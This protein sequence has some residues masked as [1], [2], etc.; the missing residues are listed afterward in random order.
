MRTISDEDFS[1]F[2]DLFKDVHGFRPRGLTPTDPEEFDRQYVDLLVQLQRQLDEQE[3]EARAAGFAS[4]RV[5]HDH[6]MQQLELLMD[7]DLLEEDAPYC[8]V[9][10][11]PAARAEML[12]P[13]VAPT[14]TCEHGRCAEERWYAGTL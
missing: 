4:H 8:R 7:I 13:K 2:S 5:Y 6:Q 9:P 14:S 1:S 11:D 12:A 10:E 3:A